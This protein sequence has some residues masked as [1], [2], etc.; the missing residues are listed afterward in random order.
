MLLRDVDDDDH[1][2]MRVLVLLLSGIQ[3][4]YGFH[5]FDSENH[6]NLLDIHQFKDRSS[7][8]SSSGL[9]NSLSL[10]N[11]MDRLLVGSLNPELVMNR[12]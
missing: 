7:S 2:S 5:L 12:L 8:N 11:L 9:L 10:M 4:P 3:T 6:K 1:L